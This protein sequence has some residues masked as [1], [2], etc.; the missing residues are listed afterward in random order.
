MSV[1]LLPSMSSPQPVGSVIGLMPRVDN[2]AQGMLVFRYSVREGGGPLHV[3]RDFSQQRD[4]V[5]R[6][7]LYEHE[8]TV[9]VT[10]RNNGTKETAD[11]DL[12]FR[13]VPRIKG[14][15][16]V[17]TPTANPLIALFSAPPCP[18]GGRFRVA[19]QRPDDKD[20]THTA[21][22]PCRGSTSNNVYVA[23]MRTDSDYR[24][25]AEVENGSNMKP[26]SWMPF[27]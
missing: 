3:I 13:T 11:G 16:P 12:P 17:V 21:F 15:Q 27:H 5:W 20:L 8:A 25:R 23:G 19:F 22:E 24:M 7:A 2:A 9:R 18:A 1:R 4:F 10:V 14:S 26:G 6:P